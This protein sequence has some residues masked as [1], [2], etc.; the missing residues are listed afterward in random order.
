MG[1][2]YFQTPMARAVWLDQAEALRSHGL[3]MFEIVHSLQ[4]LGHSDVAVQLAVAA[5]TSD[6]RRETR[7]AMKAM[8]IG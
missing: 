4:R 3:A 6:T 2:N 1:S 8:A 5:L 7:A